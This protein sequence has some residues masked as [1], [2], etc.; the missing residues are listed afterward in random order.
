MNTIYTTRQKP[1][2]GLF[3]NYSVGKI[4]KQRFN[5]RLKF[6]NKITFDWMEMDFLKDKLRFLMKK[7]FFKYATEETRQQLS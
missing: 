4:V 6:I 1:L 3:Y 5:N 7:A 2:I